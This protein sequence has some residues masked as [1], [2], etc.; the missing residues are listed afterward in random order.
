LVVFLV[1]SK[2]VEEASE[3]DERRTD[4]LY[5]NHPGFEA[6]LDQGGY[7][8]PQNI[9]RTHA[10]ILKQTSKNLNVKSRLR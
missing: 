9:G 7:T 2:A 8:A 5:K 6:A 1:Q 4:A 3:P 10:Q